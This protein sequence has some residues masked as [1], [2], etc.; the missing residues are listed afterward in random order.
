MT[1]GIASKK[2]DDAYAAQPEEPARSYIG[3]S[4]IGNPCV[5]YLSFCLRGFPNTS[6]RPSNKRI[7]LIGHKLEKQVIEDLKKAG[8]VVNEKDPFTGK[9][10]EWQ[11]FGGHISSHGD[12]LIE[13]DVG[14]EMALLEIKSMNDASWEK[15]QLYGVRTS[16][17]SYFDQMQLM[18]GKSGLRKA[19]LIAYN[20]NN[21]KYHD[22]V[23]EF[24]RFTFDGLMAKAELAMKGEGRKIAK[25]ESD[26]RCK[27]CFKLGVCWRGEKPATLYC[28]H[29]K[30]ATP[31]TDGTWWCNKHSKTSAV[32]CPDFEL[33]HPK[34][35]A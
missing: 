22:E 10:H 6:A 19:M 7:F 14:G 5:A 24:D 17:P 32:I 15:F 26:W 23:I 29:C 13:L 35:R 20:K 9:Q 18:M 34:E 1:T 11:L 27:G 2:I 30:H 4:V 16:H 28:K 8:Y 33:F 3:A 21:S 25:D 12:G 31:A